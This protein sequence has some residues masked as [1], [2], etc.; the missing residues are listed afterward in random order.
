MRKIKKKYRATKYRNL[1]YRETGIPSCNS[2][3]PFSESAKK[4]AIL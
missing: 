3:I 4:W 2:R 1:N